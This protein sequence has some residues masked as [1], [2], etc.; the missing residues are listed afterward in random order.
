MKTPKAGIVWTIYERIVRKTFDDLHSRRSAMK[1]ELDQLERALFAAREEADSLKAKLDSK[2]AWIRLQGEKVANKQSE[3]KQVEAQLGG[4][5]RILEKAGETEGD[6]LQIISRFTSEI[7]GWKKRSTLEGLNSIRWGEIL[8]IQ[9]SNNLGYEV[10]VGREVIFR[11]G[12]KDVAI[13]AV[14]LLCRILGIKEPSPDL[15]HEM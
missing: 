6:I 3:V 2:Q 13:G 1:T 14:L 12:N 15:F 11:F 10:A 9:K 8:E 7:D 4:Y 5:D